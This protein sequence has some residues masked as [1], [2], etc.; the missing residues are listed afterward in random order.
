[1]SAARAWTETVE[2]LW[3]GARVAPASSGAP[4]PGGA[5]RREL[6]FLPN[7]ERPRLLLPA[8]LP[9]VAAAALRRYSHD[10]GP[11]QRVTRTLGALAARTGLPERGLRDR[12]LVSGGGESVEDHLSDLL[13]REVVVA[14][15]LGSLRANRK[16]ILHVLTPDGGSVAFVKVGDNPTT[17]G[18]IAD[19]AAAL[20][21]LAGRSLP[22]VAVPRLLHHGCWGPL[23]L[24]VL[25]ALPTGARGERP[26]GDAP[27]SAMRTLAVSAGPDRSALAGSA[28]LKRL[29]EVPGRLTDPVQAERLAG[30]VDRVGDRHG[31]VALD[32]GAW[33]GDWTPWNMAW[34]RGVVRLWDWE[35]FADGVPHGFDLL[36]YRLQQAARTAARSPYQAPPREAA[37]ALDPL[38]LTAPAAAATAELYFLELCARYLLAA[39]EPIGGP[40]R[41]TAAD[42][43][44][45]LHT[46]AG[47][48]P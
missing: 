47:R 12:L 23:G 39:Q 20:A 34:H 46:E 3:P 18:L 36:H 33:H 28:Y 11:R 2:R 41:D 13:G 21:T 25:S 6:V 40:L 42:L 17:R 5:V 14:V 27:L 38:G 4:A 30:V 8:G 26:R 7:A 45:L 24:L 37:P 32:F 31:D 48:N 29:R 1:M 19:E 15:G 22:G 44:D 16:P 43:L 35:R 10:L 9:G